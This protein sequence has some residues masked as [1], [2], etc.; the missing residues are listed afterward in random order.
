MQ[1]EEVINNKIEILN[2]LTEEKKQEL[3][4][5]MQISDLKKLIELIEE[6]DKND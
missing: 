2:N 3:F 4:A 5:Q 6:G 1:R